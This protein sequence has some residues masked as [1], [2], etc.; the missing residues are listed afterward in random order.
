MQGAIVLAW[1]LALQELILLVYLWRE[2]LGLPASH[3]PPKAGPWGLAGVLT[4]LCVPTRCR[5]YGL[6]QFWPLS[7]SGMISCLWTGELRDF[8]FYLLLE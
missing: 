2:A 7:E 1:P 3:T 5:L 6:Q 8:H 4:A